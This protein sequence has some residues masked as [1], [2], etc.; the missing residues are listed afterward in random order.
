[1][2]PQLLNPT[3]IEIFYLG[4]DEIKIPKCIIKF[5]KWAGE[6]IKETFGG[7]P[8][9][10]M[11]NKP[12]FAELAIMTL[13]KMSGWKSRWIETYGKSKK[14]PIY[15]SEWKDDKFKNQIEDPI[16]DKNILELLSG[17]ASCNNDSYSGC[18]DVIAW[19]G[20]RIIFAESKR[21]SKDRIR[22]TQIN[23]LSAGF[24][25]GLKPENFLVVQWDM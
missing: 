7:K 5:D 13:F 16:E 23:W 24:K 15:L 14:H 6:P 21:V 11:N 2:H 10:C 19:N 4:N 22:K 18:W 25:F 17:I 12:M 20:D 3:D 1:M 8:I 9:V